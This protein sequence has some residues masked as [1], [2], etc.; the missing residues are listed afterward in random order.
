MNELYESVMDIHIYLTVLHKR[1]SS[2][3]FKVK[4]KRILDALDEL[5]NDRIASLE[6][7]YEEDF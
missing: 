6:K 4:L 3:D 1:C 2:E 7:P 5:E